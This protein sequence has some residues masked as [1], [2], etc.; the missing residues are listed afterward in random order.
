VAK[1]CTLHR[2]G[3]ATKNYSQVLSL[4]KQKKKEPG[5]PT[6]GS[7]HKHWRILS[8]QQ[9]CALGCTRVLSPG[10]VWKGKSHVDPAPRWHCLE[11]AECEAWALG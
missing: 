9:F 11:D 8:G 4:P 7:L 10:R 6:H 3:L 5:R 1:H 2:I